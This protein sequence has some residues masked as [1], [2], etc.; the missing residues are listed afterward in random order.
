MRP[1]P[2]HLPILDRER[3]PTLG[4]SVYE[5]RELEGAVDLCGADG[6]LNPAAIGFSRR[7]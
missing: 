3:P 4:K 2:D 5:E 7:D 6:R 1:L